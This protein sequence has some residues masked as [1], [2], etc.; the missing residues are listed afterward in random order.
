M[1]QPGFFLTDAQ[2]LSAE[3]TTTDATPTALF[4]LDI[5]TT[6]CGRLTVNIVAVQ[7]SATIGANRAAYSRQF[8]FWRDAAG[9]SGSDTVRSIGHDYE[10]DSAWDATVDRSSNTVR[11]MVTGAA[12]TTIHWVA[13]VNLVVA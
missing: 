13:S 10:S 9:T 1:S 3:I 7:K 12:S 6:V 11:V 8:T 4:S 5:P 2:T